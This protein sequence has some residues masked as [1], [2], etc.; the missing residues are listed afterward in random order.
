MQWNEFQSSLV[1]YAET[2]NVILHCHHMPPPQGCTWTLFRT[3][4]IR[5]A[6]GRAVHNSEDFFK[7]LPQ[8]ENKSSLTFAVLQYPFYEHNMI[9]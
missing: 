1:L 5:A 3:I 9:W 6:A 7:E 4:R 8:R 2:Q